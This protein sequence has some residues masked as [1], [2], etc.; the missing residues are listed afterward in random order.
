MYT[1]P[2]NA[3]DTPAA[4]DAVSSGKCPKIILEVLT[5]FVELALDWGKA[6]EIN[7]KYLMVL[8]GKNAGKGGGSQN[9]PSPAK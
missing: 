2:I 6:G 4:N 7:D 1:E 5:R 3:A 9:V 8:L